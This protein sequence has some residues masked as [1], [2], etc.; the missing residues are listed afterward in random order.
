MTVMNPNAPLALPFRVSKPQLN[1]ISAQEQHPLFLAGF[2]SGKTVAGIV[3]ALCLK[4]RYPKLDVGYYLPTYDL[5]KS[6]GYPGFLE[7]MELMRLRGNVVKS[8][9]IIEVRGAGNII[10]RSMDRPERIVGYKHADAVVDE[11]DTLPSIRRERSTTRSSRVT[12]RRS[13]MAR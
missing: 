13:L 1:F 10:F 11:L 6:I 12:A 9:R 3:R 2:G 5:V 4:C 8:D 7:V